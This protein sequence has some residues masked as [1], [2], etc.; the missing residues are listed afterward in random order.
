MSSSI[1]YMILLG[2]LFVF[3]IIPWIIT[4]I[5][6]FKTYIQIIR[7]TDLEKEIYKKRRRK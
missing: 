1:F 4:A 3:G 7:P 6:V 2:V 5:F